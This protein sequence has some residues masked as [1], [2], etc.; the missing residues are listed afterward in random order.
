MATTT[1]KR[2]AAAAGNGTIATAS[3]LYTCPAAT[4]AVVSSV[5]I[6][7]ASSTAYTYTLAVHTGTAFAAGS[8]VVYQATI[9]ANDT[10][11]L[12]LGVTLDATNKYLLASSSNAAVNFSVF[13]AEIA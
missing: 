8:Y 3:T 10:V 4:A 12:T 9:A 1:Y 13:G 6:C 7:N 11:S 5:V 2:L